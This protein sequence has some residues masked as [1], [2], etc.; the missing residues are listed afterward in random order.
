MVSMKSV[1][2]TIPDSIKIKIDTTII[3]VVPID[4]ILREQSKSL[5]SLLVKKMELIKK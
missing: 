2:D 1:N 5:D 4:S 3:K